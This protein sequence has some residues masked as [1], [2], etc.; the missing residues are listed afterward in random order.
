MQVI[1][2]RTRLF[3]ATFS[4]LYHISSMSQASFLDVCAA[5]TVSMGQNAPSGQIHVDLSN[6]MGRQL[7]GK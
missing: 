2:F 4:V 5:L 7:P 3:L 6:V 1:T